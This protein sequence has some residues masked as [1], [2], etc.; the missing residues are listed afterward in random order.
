VNVGKNANGGP[1]AIDGT[2]FQDGIGTHAA[3]EIAFDVPRGYQRFQARAGLDDGGT[4]QGGRPDVEFQV[5]TKSQ[6]D[7][8]EIAERARLL[9]DPGT[10][11]DELDPLVATLAGAREG[12][13]VLLRLAS[14]NK[15][16]PRASAL[17]AARLPE[18][19]DLSIRALATEFFPPA[20]ARSAG[21]ELP[22]PAEVLALAGSAPRGNRVF[23]G[24]TAQCSTCHAFHGRG[25]DVGPDLTA[26]S[27]K[28]GKP[29]ILDAILHP[30]KSIAHGFDA[31]LIETKDGLLE[32]GF[33]LADGDPV[34]LK[35][36]AGKRHVIPADEIESRT[37]QSVSTMPD[38]VA[39]GLSK[40]DL[41]DLLEFL[42]S[43]PK[44]P[45]KRLA[46]RALFDGQSLAGWTYFLEDRKARMEDVWSVKDGVLRCAGN[47][48][49]YLR[50]K[51]D[52]TSFELVV[53][54]RFDPALPPGNSGVLLRM[55]GEDK[56]WP[57]SI[58]AQLHSRN[59]GDIWNIGGFPMEAD[60]SRTEGRRTRKALPCNEKP[61]G[62]WNRYVI[63]LDGG[64]L[65]LEVN[66]EVQNRASGCEERSGKICLQ[67]EGAAIE[68]RTI[69]I[70]PI[71]R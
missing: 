3:S 20:A 1:L 61:I 37:K 59:A 42:R 16:S 12:A 30:S 35:D 57:D 13:L 43:D 18:N 49:G 22:D 67:S 6:I 56:V 10:A 34:V 32:S 24:D 70:T 39:L 40:Q 23:S 4:S 44:A 33:L 8:A 38:G 41:A 54:W 46:T 48:L 69:E 9:A 51:E 53:E 25:G 55:T 15:L 63:T 28:Y 21:P 65:T 5:W 58:E 19:P 27:V 11:E 29:E 60:P 62:E 17:A 47:P 71:A 66:G 7:P 14:E 64:E 36:T 50:T 2:V 52:F 26:I 68:F 31:W 45:G